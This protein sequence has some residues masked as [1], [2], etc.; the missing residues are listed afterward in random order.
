MARVRGCDFPDA[1]RYDVRRHV[2]YRP[3]AEGLVRA[4]ITP[5]GVALARE[6]LVFTP[7]RVGRRFAA[8]RGIAVV[9]SAK[10]V[11][12]VR[13][14]FA[15]RIEAINEALV[16][17][18]GTVNRDCYGDGWMALLRPDADDWAEGLVTGA[19]VGPAY[20]AWMEEVGFE[21]CAGGAHD[22]R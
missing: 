17:R 7:S 16:A 18:P 9:E 19:A 6:V 3:E 11:G 4:G 12:S 5:V 15:G 14:A 22:L 21:G 20:E 2:W 8:G 1:L 10:W 13:A